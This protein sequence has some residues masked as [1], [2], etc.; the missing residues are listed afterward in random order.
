[1]VTANPG[2]QSPREILSFAEKDQEVQWERLSKEE[3]DTLEDGTC[4][5]GFRLVTGHHEDGHPSSVSGA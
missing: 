1:M 5:F 2:E 4:Q 3:P